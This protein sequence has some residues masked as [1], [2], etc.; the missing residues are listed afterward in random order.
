[1]EPAVEEQATDRAYRI[2]Q[3]NAVQVF[4]LVTHGAIEEKIYTMQQKKKELI[5]AVIQ[6]GE[7]FLGKMKLEE[8]RGLFEE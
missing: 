3:K 2:G 4:K 8:I 1:M 6:P 5:N 7:N